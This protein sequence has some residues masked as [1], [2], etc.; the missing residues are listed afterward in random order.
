MTTVTS[1]EIANFRSQLSEY[2]EALKAL[3]VIEDC[4]GDLEDAA[5]VLAIRA[6]Q[7]PQRANS[8]WL[9]ALARK[10]RAVICQ[11]EFRNDLLNGNF[12]AIVEQLRKTSLCPA[13]LVTP[14]IIYVVRQ[15]VKD[16]CQPLDSV[17]WPLWCRY[18]C[19]DLSISWDWT[20]GSRCAQPHLDYT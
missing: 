6:G 9:D 7:E 12:G 4:E 3:D 5:M 2:P 14:V 10:C 20:H 13:P 19:T 18:S 11:A 15:G 17:F 1:T 8:E 16:F